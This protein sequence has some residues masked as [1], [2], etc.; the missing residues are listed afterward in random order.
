MLTATKFR[1]SETL[2]TALKF[3]KIARMRNFAVGAKMP[4]PGDARRN[5]GQLRTEIWN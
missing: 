3:C 2:A 1:D 4:A 5:F